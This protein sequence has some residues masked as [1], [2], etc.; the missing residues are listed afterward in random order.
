MTA[1]LSLVSE[2]GDRQ[3]FDRSRVQMMGAYADAT[4][5]RREFVLTYF[6][7]EY[8]G[9]CG[10]CDNCEA[11]AGAVAEGARPWEVGSTVSHAE[12]GD[13]AVQRYD[14]DQVVVLFET[15]GYRTLGV[16]L[17][18]ER[19]LLRADRSRP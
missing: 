5:C 12:W 18:L 17:V 6:G 11:G 14:G 19:D 2:Q 7:E 3:E 1:A 4:T 16:E 15:V 9:P 10:N 13:G 8:E